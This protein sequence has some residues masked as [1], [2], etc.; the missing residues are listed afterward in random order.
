MLFGLLYGFP[1]SASETGSVLSSDITSGLLLIAVVVGAG[2]NLIKTTRVYGGIIGKGLQRIGFGIVFFT[3]EALDR[4]AVNFGSSSIVG[5]LSGFLP[6][7]AIHDLLLL[8]GLFFV[9]IGF[10]KMSQA[11]KA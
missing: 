3:I 1:V 4:I 7:S 11:L 2:Y 8:L 6:E 5:Q 9:T 10:I